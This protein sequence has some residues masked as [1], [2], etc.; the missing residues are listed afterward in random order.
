MWHSF[1]LIMMFIYGYLLQIP[2]DF[3]RIPMMIGFV[4]IAFLFGTFSYYCI[5]RPL[6][7]KITQKLQM[8]ADH[9]QTEKQKVVLRQ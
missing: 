9:T 6:G 5:E 1:L 2:P 3:A 4:V 7:K 8:T